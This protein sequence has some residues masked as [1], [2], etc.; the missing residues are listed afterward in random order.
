MARTWNGHLKK[1]L[2]LIEIGNKVKNLFKI[3]RPP[4]EKQKTKLKLK[5]KIS[6][7]NNIYDS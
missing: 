1:L 6:K 7:F 3:S 2:T 5:I 4:K